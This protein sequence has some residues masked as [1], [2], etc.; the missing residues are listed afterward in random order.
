MNHPSRNVQASHKV[1]QLT[2]AKSYGLCVPDT[3]VTQDPDKFRSFYARHDVLVLPYLERDGWIEPGLFK[4]FKLDEPWDSSHNFR[5]LARMPKV[6]ALPKGVRAEPFTTLYQ[7]FTGPRTAFEGVKGVPMAE[8]TDGT[9][10]TFLVVEAA[11]AVPWTKPDDLPYHPAK[12]LPALGA[13]FQGYF[14][15]SFADGSVRLLRKDTPDATLRAM[16]TRNGGEEVNR[17][18]P[19][20]SEANP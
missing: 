1:E 17:N 15:A 11:T 2:K 5:L 10:N 12:P 6:Y 9:S 14:H 16:I 7:V 13:T 4:Q 3:L 19:P 8:F 20:V 18:Q